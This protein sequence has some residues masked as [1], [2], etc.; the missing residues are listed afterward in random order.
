MV[1]DCL[2]YMYCDQ[3]LVLIEFVKIF[4]LATRHMELSSHMSTCITLGEDSSITRHATCYIL[5]VTD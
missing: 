3:P 2:L 1:P 4:C 5:Y